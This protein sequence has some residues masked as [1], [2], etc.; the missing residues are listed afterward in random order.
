MVIIVYK[1]GDLYTLEFGAAR[2]PIMLGRSP[3]RGCVG[4]LAGSQGLCGY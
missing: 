3:T 4:C 2:W 1:V